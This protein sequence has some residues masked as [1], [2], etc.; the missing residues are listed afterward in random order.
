MRN[1]SVAVFL[2]AVTSL[3]HAQPGAHPPVVVDFATGEVGG[4]DLDH[5]YAALGQ[6]LD[7]TVH[8]VSTW[9]TESGAEEGEIR[10]KDAA[11]A[12]VGRISFTPDAGPHG[13]YLESPAFRTPEGVGVGSTLADFNA[14][15]P[16]GIRRRGDFSSER[17]DLRLQ[18]LQLGS[19][20]ERGSMFHW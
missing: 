12:T 2:L 16:L 3:C 20:C 1:V 4:V 6:V 13:L 19:G 11:D 9:T 7:G 10:G 18:G 8:R 5:S 17:R 15:E 14:A